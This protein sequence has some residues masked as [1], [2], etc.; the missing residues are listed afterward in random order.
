MAAFSPNKGYALPTVAGDVGVWGPELNQTIS[1]IDLNLGGITT[2]SM[3]GGNVTATAAQAQNLILNLTGALTAN[4]QLILPPLSGMYIIANNTT[5][6]FTVTIITSVVGAVGVGLTQGTAAP[7]FCDGTNIKQAIASSTV[8]PITGTT[9]TFTGGLTATTGTFSAVLAANGGL[10]ATT[11]TFSGPISAQSATISG[12]MTANGG[13]SSTTGTFTGTLSSNASVGAG[14]TGTGGA[15]LTA[16]DATHPGYTAFFT[17]AG[18][19]VGYAG[20]TVPSPF[21]GSLPNLALEAENGFGGWQVLGTFTVT[22]QSGTA[23]TCNVIIN[24]ASNG[25]I[26]NSVNFPTVPLTCYVANI[27]A[28]SSIYAQ[29]Q[30]AGTTIGS[31]TTASGSSVSYNTTSDQRL[32]I[33]ESVIGGLGSLIDGITPRWFRWKERP[34]EPA[35]PGFFAQ[36]VHKYWPWAVTKGRGRIGSKNF[37]PWQIDHAK[38]MPLVIAEL[39]DLRKR[40]KELE[41]LMEYP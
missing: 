14:K 19:R 21:S 25:I 39:Q 1:T 22:Q 35:E 36:Q 32:K 6:T 29:W 20:W 31:I 16:G 3:A 15:M 37:V 30:F 12:L 34:N 26:V 24:P 7:V 33:H 2:I 17:T 13:V 23:Q 5:G 8:G 28:S 9:G 4:V 27:A 41:N 38:L 40:V 18:T 11:G 10:T